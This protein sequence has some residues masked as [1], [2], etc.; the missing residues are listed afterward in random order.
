MVKQTSSSESM[1]A[2]DCGMCDSS[3]KGITKDLSTAKEKK[4]EINLTLF[5]SCF[6]CPITIN[7]NDGKVPL[8]DHKLV[9]MGTESSDF[10]NRQPERPMRSR[11]AGVP[12]MKSDSHLYFA[13]SSSED[14]ED[15]S[16]ASSFIT[17]SDQDMEEKERVFKN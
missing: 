1:S 17:N 12:P 7:M 13:S 2:E 14:D 16:D 4:F 11:K 10:T 15:M 5:T 3:P 8:L 9:N 6:K